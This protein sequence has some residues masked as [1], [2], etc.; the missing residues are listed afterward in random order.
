MQGFREPEVGI[1]PV[2]AGEA[3]GA[4]EEGRALGEGPA[5]RF[6]VLGRADQVVAQRL[7]GQVV[8]DGNPAAPLGVLLDRGVDRLDERPRNPET[9]RPVIALES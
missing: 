1:I 5:V 9:P 2:A 6:R 4:G 8:V 7:V 3:A